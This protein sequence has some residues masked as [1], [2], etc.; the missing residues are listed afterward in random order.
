MK[1]ENEK[2][3]YLSEA[4]HNG[5]QYPNKSVTTVLTAGTTVDR[6]S[7][8]RISGCYAYTVE[9]YPLVVWMESE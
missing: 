8:P 2:T 1:I 6:I 4:G 7:W 3:V 9:T 5:F